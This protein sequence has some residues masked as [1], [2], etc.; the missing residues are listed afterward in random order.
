MVVTKF[1]TWNAPRLEAI[2]MSATSVFDG[3]SFTTPVEMTN[4]ILTLMH[5]LLIQTMIDAEHT[6][7]DLNGDLKGL[8]YRDL[9]IA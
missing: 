5:A 3:K 2:S 4:A 7:G 8:T 6:L 9:T 1:D